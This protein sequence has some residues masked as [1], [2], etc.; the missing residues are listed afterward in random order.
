MVKSYRWLGRAL[1]ELGVRRVDI[2]L[3]DLGLSAEQLAGGGRGFSFQRD[4]PL[5]MTFA[6][7]ADAGQLTA[8]EI[9]N[10]W[11][12]ETLADTIFRYGEERFARRIAVAIVAA[13]A[14][15]PLETT[16]ALV[17]VIESAVPFWYARGRLHPA[18]RTFQA[19]R[20][21]V[22]DELG[23]I[24]VGLEQAWSALAPG[25]RLAVITFHSLE[26]RLVKEKFKEWLAA[27]QG[28]KVTAHAVRPTYDEIRRNPRARSAQLR[29]IRKLA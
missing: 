3:F 12:E 2:A 6:A 23:A 19:L 11:R 25:G 24:A 7:H 9:V 10:H 21:A 1:D 29:V 8:A 17:A 4:E 27:K 28:Q 5:Q 14:R 15:A 22:N 20:I 13:R 18:T 26:A 16:A